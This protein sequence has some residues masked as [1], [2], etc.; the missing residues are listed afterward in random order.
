MSNNKGWWN[1]I[2]WLG[3][4]Y[5]NIK[6]KNAPFAYYGASI[7][8]TVIV[9]TIPV[10]FSLGFVFSQESIINEISFTAGEISLFASILAIAM[11]I[12]GVSMII[13]DM[14]NFVKSR[15]TAKLIIK[16][17]KEGYKKFPNELLSYKE[18]YYSRDVVEVG[19][20]E[21]DDNRNLEQQVTRYNAEYEVDLYHKFIFE[22]S[23]DTLFLCGIARV[24]F[25]VAYG[26]RLKSSACINYIE[27]DHATQK[28]FLLDDIN[29]N[30][31]I[32]KE[33]EVEPSND[34]D[35]GIAIGFTCRVKKD[36]LPENLQEHTLFISSSIEL[37]R[38][39]IKNQENIHC[40]ANKI[41]RIIDDFSAKKEC[42]R[43]HLFLSV[44]TSFAMEL[45][46]KYQ[47]GMH[48][49]WVIHNYNGKEYSWAL[50]LS[51]EELKIFEG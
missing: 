30:I 45:G 5:S 38:L 6:K 25:L 17:M 22:D 43:I 50:E 44:Q 40:L 29:K 28:S 12:L 33:N 32:I 31:D 21:E 14:F 8:K 11:I 1:K 51:K 3:N 18:K 13:Y 39:L 47:E 9:A 23:V 4:L 24:P 41:Q 19:L 10:S 20:T 7:I 2:Q 36:Q 15:N 27:R 34:G 42:T 16:G 48:K 46:R 37:D 35:I 26:Y 49:N